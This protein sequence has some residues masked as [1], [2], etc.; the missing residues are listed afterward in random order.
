MHT[1]LV[2]S[3][4]AAVARLTA[5]QW[6]VLISLHFNGLIQERRIAKREFNQGIAGL[7]NYRFVQKRIYQASRRRKEKW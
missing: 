1:A 7:Q 4:A 3:L 2:P 5:A 6:S